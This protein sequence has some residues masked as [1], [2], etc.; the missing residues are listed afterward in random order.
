MGAFRGTDE[1]FIRDFF[2]PGI[3]RA[4]GLQAAQ[5]LTAKYR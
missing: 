4:G 1:D 5:R 3:L 2:V